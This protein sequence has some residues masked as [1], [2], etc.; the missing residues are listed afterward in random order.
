MNLSLT[1]GPNVIKSFSCST[2]MSM[3][4]S[5]LVNMNK[6]QQW[7]AFSYLVAEEISRSAMFGQ[8]FA[9]V[10]NLRIISKI[11]FMLT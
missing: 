1:S 5:L 4:F 10:S 7:L 2:Q 11:N 3:M 9:F 6:P 8:N